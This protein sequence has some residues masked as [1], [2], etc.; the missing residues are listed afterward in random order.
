MFEDIFS[1][2][3]CF[4]GQTQSSVGNKNLCNLINTY[5]FNNEKE[6]HFYNILFI[7]YEYL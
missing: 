6:Q 7:F 5:I 4:I 1:K 3:K 2:T